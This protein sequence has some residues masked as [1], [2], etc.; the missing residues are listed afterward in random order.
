MSEQQ[1]NDKVAL[2][3]SAYLDAYNS[4]DGEKVLQTLEVL[5]TE[6]NLDLD[7]LSK[8]KAALDNYTKGKRRRSYNKSK[9]RPTQQAAT[10]RPTETPDPRAEEWASLKMNGLVRIVL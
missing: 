7:N 3:K 9:P 5:T 8:Q 6:V 2:A 4:G 10:T 1:L